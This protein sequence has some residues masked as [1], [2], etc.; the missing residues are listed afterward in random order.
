MA[1]ELATHILLLFCRS[2]S[3]QS[4]CLCYVM[5]IG[6]VCCEARLFNHFMY[7][8]LPKSDCIVFKTLLHAL[9]LLGLLYIFIAS[10]PQVAGTN[11][12]LTLKIVF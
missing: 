5:F 2:L 7:F 10:V 8:V 9:C 1:G 3:A 12:P 6:C 11:G 4:G